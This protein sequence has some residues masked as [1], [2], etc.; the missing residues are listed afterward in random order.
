[1]ARP[2]LVSNRILVS[3]AL[4]VV[5]GLA[6]LSREG[7]VF[8]KVSRLDYLLNTLV[9]QAKNEIALV[10]DPKDTNSFVLPV[11]YYDQEHPVTC[12]ISA[13]RT[14]LTY[15]GTNVTEQE[16]VK[17]L[18]FST[19]AG[20]SPFGIW[21]DPNQ[22][23]VGDVNGSIYE[24]TGYGVYEKPIA[25]LASTYRP[26]HVLESPNL[27]KVIKEVKAGNPVIAW[28]ILK[29]RK[30]I[31][32]QTPEGKTVKAFGGEHA[33]VVIGWS[34]RESSPDQIILVDPIYGLIRMD[35]SDFLEGWKLLDNRAV[36]VYR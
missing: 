11:P 18:K 17:K 26:A 24:K 19:T 32:W 34:G 21:G 6:T 15:L 25:D 29:D 36:V 9:Y 16:L 13:L 33:R 1:M 5:L 12:E 2:R 22:G 4:V 23:F 7:A 14:A 31:Y 35:T 3:L 10:L 28:G 20:M 30:P 27:S 8:H